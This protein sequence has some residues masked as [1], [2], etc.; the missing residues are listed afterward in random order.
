MA[1]SKLQAAFYSTMTG[2]AFAMLMFYVISDAS[3]SSI[4]TEE[5]AAV[6]TVEQPVVQ[7]NN[8]REL[9]LAQE[10]LECLAL[11]VY[12]ESRNQPILGQMATA[13][14]VLNR[15]K[16]SGFPDQI[17]GVI[18]DGGSVAPCQF[19]WYCDGKPDTPYEIAP[20]RTA[21]AV[22]EF[23]LDHREVDMLNGAD[24]FHD[25]SIDPPGWASRMTRVARIGDT[26]YYA[27]RRQD[28]S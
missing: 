14:V 18:K 8:E 12:H 7:F 17:C 15:A 23:V 6:V 24:H 26:I 28:G 22:A 27:S 1:A 19:S 21:K 16:S 20:W 13:S 9:Q 3:P 10:E 11:A 25:T 5:E 2:A 4:A